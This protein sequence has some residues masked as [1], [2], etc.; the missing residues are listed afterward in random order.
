MQNEKM[1]LYWELPWWLSGKEFTCQSRRCGFDL[2]VRKTPWRKKWQPIPVF[3][4]G[5]SHGQRILAGYSPWGHKK[6][7]HDL[8]TKQQQHCI[9]HRG[10]F[11][12]IL[13][14]TIFRANRWEKWKQWQTL[15][16]WALKSCETVTAAIKLKDASSLEE[17]LWQ[18]NTAY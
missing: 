10:P 1:P 12:N 2:W 5:R 8:V 17:K 15:F 4:P 18:I 6:V 13:I 16:S 9:E 3:L 14:I 7:R 11:R